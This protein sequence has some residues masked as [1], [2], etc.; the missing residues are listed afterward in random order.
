MKKIH[1]PKYMKKLERQINYPVNTSTTPVVIALCTL[2]GRMGLKGILLDDFMEKLSCESKDG[3]VSKRDEFE[4]LLNKVKI[5]IS[6]S[7]IRDIFDEIGYRDNEG[8]QEMNIC[9]FHQ[10][11]L[12]TYKSNGVQAS[13]W[14]TYV[15]PI[16]EVVVLQDVVTGEVSA[17][18]F[19]RL[20]NI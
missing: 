2:D 7:C 14:K 15:S 17:V 19:V 11:M 10:K 3:V 13:R 20:T 6:S 12:S 9:D 5:H 18:P 4:S 16:H 8:I 1:L